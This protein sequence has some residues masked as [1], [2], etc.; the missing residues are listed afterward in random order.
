MIKNYEI[1]AMD[2]LQIILAWNENVNSFDRDLIKK[3]QNLVN[4]IVPESGLFDFAK[5]EASLKYPV[6]MGLFFPISFVLKKFEYGYVEKK[7]LKEKIPVV[8]KKL[9]VDYDLESGKVPYC[10]IANR[11]IEAI[12]KCLDESL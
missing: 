2:K 7:A 11:I 12:N 4:D 1:K 6:S 8:I 9:A 5:S 3:V 10:G